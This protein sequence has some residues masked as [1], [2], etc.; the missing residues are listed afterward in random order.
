MTSS[1]HVS[2]E[3]HASPRTIRRSLLVLLG[4]VT[5]VAAACQPPP[6][7]APPAAS[8]F[9]FSGSG[10]GHGV[11][12]SQWGARGMAERGNGYAQILGYYYNGATVT[13]RGASSNI[14]VLATERQNTI[15]LRAVGNHV[16]IAGTRVASGA[17]VTITRTGSQ[18][19]LSGAINRSV[20]QSLAVGYS[21]GSS[22][23]VSAPGYNFHYGRVVVR[24]DQAGGLRA[25]VEN[26]TMSQYLYGLGEMSSSWPIEAIKAQATASR[27]FAEKKLAGGRTADYDLLGTVLHQ[28]YTGTRHE[29]A[30]WRAAVDTTAGH[31]VTY[32]GSL[33]DAVYS[34]SSGGHT[35]NSE[36]V[37]VSA[38]PYLR[39]KPDPYDEVA[40]NPHNGWSRTYTGGQLG[41]WFGLGTVT[42]VQ[43]L[44]NTGT[45]GRVDKATIRLTGTGGTRDV[46]GPTFRSTVN[47]NSPS[48][49]LMST[50]FVVK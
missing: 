22:I 11:G 9:T 3:R 28:A 42:S 32:N 47:R 24:I 19:I 27:T 46:S 40:S 21:D 1:R 35:E 38:V 30:R 34:A 2:S 18:L 6:P 17:V 36:I 37:W 14:R 25:I 5:V 45:S 26:L 10:W 31:V 50:K 29:D 13:A 20:S 41:A 12:M 8:S 33:I 4:L 15:T 44:G 39:G 23:T 43:I 16:T 49:Q 7:P 48:A